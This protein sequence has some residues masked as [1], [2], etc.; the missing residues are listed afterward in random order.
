MTP[1]RL[2]EK[3]EPRGMFPPRQVTKA[4]KAWKA[5]LKASK[6]AKPSKYRAKRCVVD[7]ET[8]DSQ[9]EA[10]EWVKLKALAR[11]EKIYGLIRQQPYRL[12]VHGRLIATYISDF[13]WDEWD[14][15]HAA[16]LRIVA[17]VKGVK[18]RDYLIKKKLM[19]AIY[20]IDI[21]EL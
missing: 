9:R 8:F 3:A 19:K 16:L 7:G 6:A 15:E 5:A 10:R 4:Q 1:P 14:A 20:G 13:E 21:R 2:S 17:D 11:R 18:T 12:L